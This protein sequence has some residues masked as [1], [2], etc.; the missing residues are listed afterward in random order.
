MVR[1]KGGLLTEDLAKRFNVS[2]G[3]VSSIVTSWINLMYLDLKLLCELPFKKIACANQSSA[4][5][6][7]SDVRVILDCTELFVQNPSKLDARKQLFSNYKHHITYKFLVGI[8]PQL[9]ITY[10]SKMY[11]GRASD[12]YITS[13]SAD[14]LINLEKE[15]GSVMT[16]RGFLVEGILSD[17]GVKLIMPAFK[18]AD[19]PQLSAEETKTSESISRVR[20]HI[21]RA[22]QRI[23]TY[24]IFDGELKLSMKDIAEQ[25]FTVCAFLVNFQTPIVKSGP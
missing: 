21:E 19:R 16:D 15:K 25:V 23:K 3:T 13:D 8:G 12:K 17:M 7:F 6:S 1:L 22:I 4:I 10:V 24:H 20:I 9:G 11:G 5:G 14:L 2:T 18:G